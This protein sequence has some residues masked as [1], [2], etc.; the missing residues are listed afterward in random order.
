MKVE[1]VAKFK[2]KGSG[3]HKSRRVPADGTELRKLYDL[4]CRNK[5]EVITQVFTSGTYAS[6]EQLRNFYGLDIRRITNRKWCLVGEWFGNRY[7]DYLAKE[8]K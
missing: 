2:R 4:F 5:G 8:Y 1:S 3:K 7:V 6:L